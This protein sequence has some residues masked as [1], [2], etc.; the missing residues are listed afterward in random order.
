MT[1]NLPSALHIDPETTCNQISIFL[2]QALDRLERA[3]VVVPV[4]GGLD[5]SVVTALTAR[6]FAKD[7]IHLLNLPERD[8]NP[9]HKKHAKLLAKHYG[10]PLKRKSL[11][12]SLRASGS[13]R[14]LPLGFF[15]SRA[16]R[17]KVIK[18]GKKRLVHEK[19]KKLM[20]SRQHSK[21]NT[22]I[23]RGN[24]YAMA[25]H[26][27]RMVMVYRYAERHNLMVVGAA[28]LT[29]WLTGTFSQW[30]VDHCA[31]VMP[32]LHLY[33][34]QVEQIGEYLQIPAYILQK[35][36][37][38]DVLPGI[39]DKGTLLGGFHLTDPLLFDI[40]AGMSKSDL[41]TKYDSESVEYILTLMEASA[42]MR[43]GALSLLPANKPKALIPNDN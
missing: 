2:K 5:S 9:I 39:P 17:E 41:E 10:I 29:E 34:T 30:G 28:N 15:P 8:S 6:S 31:D 11:T 20:I 14:L 26:R 40:Q 13:Y 24:A 38:P 42:H 37:D 21:N 36:A 43:N 35:G 23:A 32:I 27:M 22:W 18:L 12:H 4:S 16:L 19:W 7:K 1:P 3:G 25:K 33:R